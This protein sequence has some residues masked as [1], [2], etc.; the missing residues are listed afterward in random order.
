MLTSVPLRCNLGRVTHFYMDE[1]TVVKFV[2]DNMN[3]YDLGVALARRYNLQGAE[4]IFKQQFGRLMQASKL[5]EAMN[6]A[7]TSPQVGLSAVYCTNH[8]NFVFWFWLGHSPHHRDHQRP[9]AVRSRPGSL[10]VL[11]AAP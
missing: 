8:S 2:C 9:E 10:A 1:K 6:L 7:V 4:N 3:D 11:P 5:E